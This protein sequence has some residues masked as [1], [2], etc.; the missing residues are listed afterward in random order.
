MTRITTIKIWHICLFAFSL[1]AISSS[2]LWIGCGIW[3]MHTNKLSLETTVSLY[4]NKNSHVQGDD[5][6]TVDHRGTG[7]REFKLVQ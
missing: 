3:L 4:H 6:G 2:I 7:R 5:D 1:G